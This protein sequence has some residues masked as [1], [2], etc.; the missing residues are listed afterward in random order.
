MVS[1]QCEMASI[2]IQIKMLHSLGLLCRSANNHVPP[3]LMNETQTRLVFLIHL[4][5]CVKVLL[6]V[7]MVMRASVAISIQ[8]LQS[9]DFFRMV[10]TGE[11]H[12]AKTAVL[13]LTPL[14]F[15]EDHTTLCGP[16]G[17]PKVLNLTPQFL[18]CM[19]LK[20]VR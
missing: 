18:Q 20:L 5:S 7:H 12:T 8:N 14:V 17:T 13:N 19:D 15:L 4:A 11:A 16:L 3:G 2:Q 9:P 1:Y 10:T 6:P